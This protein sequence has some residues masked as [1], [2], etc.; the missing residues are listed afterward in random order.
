M[1]AIDTSRRRAGLLKAGWNERLPPVHPD[2]DGHADSV[3]YSQVLAEPARERG[4]AVC[5]YNANHV[6][7]EAARVLGERANNVLH[8]PRTTSAPTMD[9]RSSDIARYNHQGRLTSKLG[10]TSYPLIASMTLA[11]T[12]G[13]ADQPVCTAVNQTGV[14]AA[15]PRGTP[16][17]Q[18]PVER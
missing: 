12:R 7:D 4:W 13:A 14:R 10:S 15:S 8:S 16:A 1:L 17:T 9:E 11:R 5:F 6:E 3:T 2:Q 18:R